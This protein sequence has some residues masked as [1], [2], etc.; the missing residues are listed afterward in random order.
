MTGHGRQGTF[1]WLVLPYLSDWQQM[2]ICC[3]MAK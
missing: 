2:S 3:I 1:P